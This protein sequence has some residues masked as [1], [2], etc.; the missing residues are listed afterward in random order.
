MHPACIISQLNCN[1]ESTH[2]ASL[3]ARLLSLLRTR[4][5]S[6]KPEKDLPLAGRRRGGAVAPWRAEDGPRIIL[7]ISL[8]SLVILSDRN[9]LPPSFSYFF[10]ASSLTLAIMPVDASFLKGPILGPKEGV[11]EVV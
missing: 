2:E 9:F 3:S 10:N 5:Y 1:P 11:E 8:F 4:T 7:Q 6:S